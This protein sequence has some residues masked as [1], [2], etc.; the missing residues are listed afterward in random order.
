MAQD[1]DKLDEKNQDKLTDEEI[2]SLA[3]DRF[4][5]AVEAEAITR[6][7]ELDD[8]KFMC[9]EQW[10]TAIKQA[11]ALDQRPCLTVNR[12]PQFVRQITNDQRQNRPSIKVNPV[13]DAADIETAKVYQWMVRHVE[14]RSCADIAYDTGFEWATKCG[15]GYYRLRTDYVDPLSFQQEIRIELIKDRFSVYVDPYFQQPDGSDIQ[16]GFIFEDLSHEEYKAQYP[17]SDLSSMSDWDSLGRNRPS[18]IQ[19]NTV[20]VAEYYYKVFEDVTVCLLSDGSVLEKAQIVPEILKERKLKV[21]KERETVLPKIKWCKINGVEILDRTDIPGKYI[22]IIPIIG[23][24]QIVDGKK[25]YAGIIR[26]A[27]DPQTNYNFWISSMAETI[28]LAPKAPFVGASGQFE[29]YE[30]KWQTANIK[31]HAYL[32]YNQIDLNGQPAPPPQRQAVEPP[33]QAMSMAMQGA[34]EDLKSTTGIYDATL[35]NRSN[36]TSGIA[37]QRRNAQAQVSNFHFNDNLS[38]SLRHT[39][40]ILLEWIPEVYDTPQT[41]HILGEDGE[42][43]QVKINQIFEEAGEQKGHFLDAGTYDVT[44]DTGPSYQTKRQEAVASM[45]DLAR[46]APQVLQVAGDIMVR[47]M[48]WPGAQEIA[49]RIKKSLPP[50]LTADDKDQ[51]QLPPQVQQKLAQ[52]SQMTQALSQEVQKLS[53]VIETKQ[54]ENASKERIEAMRAQNTLV[55]ELLKH[56]A[57]DGQVAFQEEMKVLHKRLDML[58]A[59]QPIDD[60][61]GVP[62]G[63]SAIPGNN[64]N[65]NQ[66]TGG[67]SPGQPM[68]TQP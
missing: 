29:G 35:G 31:N 41:I 63:G 52:Y 1:K 45:L 49:D 34:I 60:G 15:I 62:N 68:E 16:W 58:G 38:R 53:Q 17:D 54:M 51:T 3:H 64:Q 48:D 65:Q 22:P 13:D 24:E 55:L 27:K 30:E 59:N 40:R 20:R 5:I 43:D 18:W 25:V 37:I 67:S 6:A 61:T 44:V 9:G 66:P 14:Y 57:K 19:E 39:G 23:E 36:E 33:I 42:V 7:L 10:P 12:I 11:R 2:L 4:E 46:S 50:Q 8:L 47:H 28:A 56:N 26:H 32:E 21:V